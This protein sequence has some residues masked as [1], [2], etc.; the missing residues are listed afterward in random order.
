MKIGYFCVIF[1]GILEI[2]WVSGLKYANT[3]WEFCLT[4]VAILVSFSLMIV[5][6]MRLEVGIA[7]ALYVGIGSAGI[8][9]GD[10]LYFNA[11][12]NA[13]QIVVIVV[14]ILSVVGLKL[15]SKEVDLCTKEGK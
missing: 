5:A 10:M 3:T 15:V 2:F 4:I 11:P 9:L 13:L 14:L 8:T 6:S 1:G 7:Y 12:Y